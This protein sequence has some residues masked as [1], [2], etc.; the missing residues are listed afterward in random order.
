MFIRAHAQRQRLIFTKNSAALGELAYK[1]I[2]SKAPIFLSLICPV[3]NWQGELSRF[4]KASGD[5]LA[6]SVS[7]YEIII[8]DNASQD[9]SLETL[10]Q[11]TANDGLPN[12]QVFA[13][14]QQVSHDV[15]AY[16]GIENALGDFLII[17]DPHQDNL[18]ALAPML[19]QAMAGH[20]LVFVQNNQRQTQTLGYRF[21]EAIFKKIYRALNA[22]DFSPQ[23]SRLRLLSRRVANYL[24]QYPQPT[25]A[26]RH[27]PALAGF[28]K[29]QLYYSAAPSATQ[30]QN[31]SNSIE[32]GIQLLLA[33]TR[34]PL[35]LVTLLSLFG[36]GANIIY[37]VYVLLIALFKEDVAEGWVSLSLQ[38][39]G[40]FF[41][42]SLVLLVLGEYILQMAHNS[43]AGPQYYI[44]QEMTSKQQNRHKKL[45][46]D[47]SS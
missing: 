1:N 42:I 11:L 15:A 26:Y 6:Q 12:L 18:S 3:R 43:N 28:T 24:Q 35:R 46:I 16:V 22:V 14:S 33:T 23:S 2:M 7:D 31:L 45:N 38:Q 4:L 9:N 27:L 5:L 17:L 21:F 47:Q 44:A 34:L 36:A 30:P 39:S 8:I 40:M 20:D 19:E 10:R 29:A 32:R 37:S 13:L 25:L 41:L